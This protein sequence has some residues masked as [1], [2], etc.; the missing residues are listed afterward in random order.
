MGKLKTIKDLKH[1]VVLIFYDEESEVE[2]L[3]DL[4]DSVLPL[5]IT[6]TIWD[7][8]SEATEDLESLDED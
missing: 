1:K 7:N 2:N 8:L 6:F 3:P 5:N 4:L